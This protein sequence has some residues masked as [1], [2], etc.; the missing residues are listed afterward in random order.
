M[1]R[2]HH[3]PPCGTCTSCLRLRG[4]PFHMSDQLNTNSITLWLGLWHT[5]R[6]THTH[7]VCG[8]LCGDA[9]GI[10]PQSTSWATRAFFNLFVCVSLCVCVCVCV[11]VCAWLLHYEDTCQLLVRIYDQAPFSVPRPQVDVVMYIYTAWLAWGDERCVFI[12]PSHD[13]SPS[14]LIYCR[15]ETKTSCL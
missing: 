15:Y 13:H 14:K 11:C 5:H 4:F 7:S 3:S 1:W 8:G 2:S 9:S 10:K 12:C 6:H